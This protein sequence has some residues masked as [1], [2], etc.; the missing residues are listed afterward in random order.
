V[1]TKRSIEDQTAFDNTV[2]AAKLHGMR[3]DERA[4]GV[5]KLSL[6]V[7]AG[8]LLVALVALALI[9]GS[10]AI[11]WSSSQSISSCRRVGSGGR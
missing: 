9:G 1:R 2:D 8:S 6:W 5:A 7:G 4:L 3:S 11:P 10:L